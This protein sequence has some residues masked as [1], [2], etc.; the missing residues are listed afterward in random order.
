MTRK[1]A[2]Q[3]EARARALADTN[4]CLPAK[5]SMTCS[6]ILPRIAFRAFRAS[7]SCEKKSSSG[8]LRITATSSNCAYTTVKS[9][10]RPALILER[11]AN[12]ERMTNGFDSAFGHYAEAETLYKRLFEEFPDD[13]TIG[14]GLAAL[15][16]DF[17]EVL[18]MNW[19]LTEAF[20][21]F[22]EVLELARARHDAKADDPDRRR[23]LASILSDY[24]VVLGQAD[25]VAEGLP[26]CDEAVVAVRRTQQN[27][28]ASQPTARPA[29][30]LDVAC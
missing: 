7:S 19:R 29:T 25:R 5:R 23:T 9:A 17:A 21:V 1:L 3:E 12:I 14:D 13:E 20:P 10:D 16:R 6:Y 2:R 18:R 15:E 11:L 22:A 30:P 24:G 26:R 27:G 28:A 4:S 8:R